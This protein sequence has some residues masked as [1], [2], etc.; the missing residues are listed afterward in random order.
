MQP[1]QA[2][3]IQPESTVDPAQ[4]QSLYAANGASVASGKSDTTFKQ[5]DISNPTKPKDSGTGMW[6][7]IGVA[8]ALILMAVGLV[9]GWKHRK[10]RKRSLAMVDI[11]A[12]SS[13]R[14]S[15]CESQSGE[16]V[17]LS[18]RGSISGMSTTSDGRRLSV[19]TAV[20]VDAPLINPRSSIRASQLV[21]PVVDDGKRS[22][23]IT[24]QEVQAPLINPRSSIRASQLGETVDLSR[25][26][27]ISGMSVTGKDKRLSNPATQDGEAPLIRPRSSISSVDRVSVSSDGF[28]LVSSTATDEEPLSIL[29]IE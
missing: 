7:G 25:N 3:V 10:A 12:P 8:M 28:T 1:Q 16:S 17:S 29:P 15:M 5:A 4:T 21:Q 22:S 18:R 23:T 14:P 13:R 9:I 24:M 26:G 6:I 11:E 20:G 27:S 19:L 2:S